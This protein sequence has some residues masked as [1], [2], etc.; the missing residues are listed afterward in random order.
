MENVENDIPIN[1]E[2]TKSMYNIV[3][4]NSCQLIIGII[5]GFIFATFFYKELFVQ[6]GIEDMLYVAKTNTIR[7][8]N[9]SHYNINP[10]DKF[11]DGFKESFNVKKCIGYSGDPISPYYSMDRTLLRKSGKKC[12]NKQL[13]D[14]TEYAVPY[15]DHLVENFDSDRTYD[16]GYLSSPGSIDVNIYKGFDGYGRNYGPPVLP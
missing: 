7:G 15:N 4:G 6:C 11:T 3:S 13:P 12:N 14:Y 9:G 5:V 2:I 16:E 8:G 10:N 1:P